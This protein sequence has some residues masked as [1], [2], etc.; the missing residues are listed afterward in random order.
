M[1]VLLALIGLTKTTPA[2][3]PTPPAQTAGSSV[4]VTTCRAQLDKPPLKIGYTNDAK[5]TATEIDFTIV[6]SAGVVR[7]IKDTG[8]FATGIPILHVFD[9]PED[10]SPLG[11]SAARCAITRIVYADGTTWVN[12]SPP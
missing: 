12:P 9:L 11:L 5:K 4:T 10:T 8:T 2:P 1:L 6:D 3:S 7:T